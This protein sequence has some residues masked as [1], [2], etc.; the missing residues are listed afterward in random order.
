MYKSTYFF[1]LALDF[2][3]AA[4]LAGAFFAAGA[5]FL[6]GAF[7]VAISGLLLPVAV[8]H[9]TGSDRTYTSALIIKASR[10]LSRGV[11]YI[12]FTQAYTSAL[13]GN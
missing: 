12:F 1:F 8:C 2:A 9:F 7:F 13:I 11:G 6:A 4:F 5:A 10:H 3:A